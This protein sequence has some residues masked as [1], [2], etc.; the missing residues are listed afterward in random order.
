[1]PLVE[2]EMSY[3]YPV[4]LVLFVSKTDEHVFYVIIICP[5]LAWLRRT[6]L[7]FDL[8][9]DQGKPCW[10]LVY[11]E[12]KDRMEDSQLPNILIWEVNLLNVDYLFDL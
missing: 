4:K 6:Q 7:G 1:M 5:F 8:R 9:L 3:I 12:H 2:Q 11:A 10:N